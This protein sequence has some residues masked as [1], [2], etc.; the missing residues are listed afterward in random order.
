MSNNPISVRFSDAVSKTLKLFSRGGQSPSDFIREAVDEKLNRKGTY[1][2][3]VVQLSMNPQKT[4]FEIRLKLSSGIHLSVE[5]ITVLCI[6]WHNAYLTNTGFIN[7][8]YFT[9]ILDITTELLIEADFHGLEVDWHYVKGILEFSEIGELQKATTDLIPI[10]GEAYDCSRAE[11]IC[12]TV[13][14][15]SQ[16]LYK[17]PGQILRSIFTDARLNLLYPLAVTGSELRK[18]SFDLSYWN[19]NPVND[20]VETL[21]IDVDGMQFCLDP[22]FFRA[23]VEGNHH[24][25]P[26]SDAAMISLITLAHEEIAIDSKLMRGDLYILNGGES[27]I[28]HQSDGY[29]LHVSKDAFTSLLIQ[30]REG[31]KCELWEK[32]INAYKYL[33]GDY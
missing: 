17:Y 13:S 26:F 28:L 8:D 25:Y 11:M 23:I 18:P 31:T 1:W 12:R 10:K 33:N 24:C 9:E 6:Y 29:R 20:Y 19:D 30:I 22:F 3:G 32:T 2:E 15:V 16:H 21:K 14:Q 27:Y 5:E 4:L 7:R